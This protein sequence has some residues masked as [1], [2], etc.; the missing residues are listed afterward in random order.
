MIR[1]NEVRCNANN[2]NFRKVSKLMSYWGSVP[3]LESAKTTFEVKEPPRKC[4]RGIYDD[5]Y[6]LKKIIRCYNC[7]KE[8]HFQIGKSVLQGNLEKI[9]QECLLL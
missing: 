9:N 8:G 2:Q 5:D 1:E 3:K 7:G 6:K 4:F